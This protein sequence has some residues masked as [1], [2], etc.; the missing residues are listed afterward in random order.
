MTDEYDVF[1]ESE[2]EE[3]LLRRSFEVGRGR[4]VEAIAEEIATMKDDEE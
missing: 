4:L 2:I 1:T 3:R